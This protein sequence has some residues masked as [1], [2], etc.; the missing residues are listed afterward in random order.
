VA[1][2]RRYCWKAKPAETAEPAGMLIAM[3][4]RA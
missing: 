1:P 2:L 3:A 4:E